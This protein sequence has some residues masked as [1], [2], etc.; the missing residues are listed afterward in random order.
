MTSLR[1]RLKT[2]EMPRPSGAIDWYALQTR[3]AAGHSARRELSRCESQGRIKPGAFA[4]W[5]NIQTGAH[6]GAPVVNPNDLAVRKGAA[7]MDGAVAEHAA[8][9]GQG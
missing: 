6:W 5:V 4:Q 1:A 2:G 7:G 9:G 3:L 8:R